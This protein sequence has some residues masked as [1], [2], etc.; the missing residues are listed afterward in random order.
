MT[1]KQGLFAFLIAAPLAWSVQ[2]GDAPKLP[3]RVVQ[4]Q[5]PSLDMAG[6]APEERFQTVL[7]K[8]LG[9]HMKREVQII[10]LPRNR[11]LAAL[12]AG[13]GDI[14]CGYT[15]DWLGGAVDWSRPFIPVID[16]VAWLPRVA[17]VHSLADLK[18]KRVGTVLGFHYPD[19]E[20]VLGAGFRRDD[21]PSEAM[22]LRKLV[23]GRFDYALTKRSAVQTQIRKG[24]V[25][26]ELQQFV[27]KELK[28][29]CAVSRKGHIDVKE[30][31]AAIDAMER[32]GEM[33]RLMQRG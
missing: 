14:L 31:D 12:E 6:R 28:T 27:F 11:L 32:S 15:P 17:P 22:S 18:G 8:L 33:E 9:A 7:G 25:P 20:S 21:A 30:L 3:L 1:F 10:D 2:A 16:V 26:A 29:M 19:V 13:E 5:E 24:N 23:A 4:K